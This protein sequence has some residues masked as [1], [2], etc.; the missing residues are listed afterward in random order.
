MPTDLQRARELFLHAVGK[1]P[2]EQWDDYVAAACGGDTGLRQQVEHFLQVHRE[3]G[4]FLER[5]AGGLKGTGLFTPAPADAATIP[6]EGPGAVL[7][8]YKLVQQIGEGGMG[9]VWMAQQTEPVKRLVALKVIKPGMDSRQVLVR[10]EA[11]RQ[12]LALMDHPHIAKVLDAGTTP[13][14]RPYFVMELVKG[15]PL[16]KYCDEHRLPLKERLEL[17]VPACQA[18]QHAHTK[19]VIHRDVKPSN[20]LVASYDGVPVPKV[21]DFGIAKATSQQLTEHALVTGFGTVVGT[22]E[23]MS[24]EQA[25]LNQLDIDTRSDIYSLGVLLYELLTGTTPLEKKRLK[26]AALLEVLRL[27]REEE[28]PKPSTRLSTTDELPVVAANRGL[29]PKKLSGLVRGELD[30]IVMK[31]L[32]KDRN[33]RYDTANGFAQDIQR[34]LADEPVQACPPSAGYR[35]KKFLRRNKGPVLAATLIVLALIGGVI[36]TT[37][38]MMRAEKASAAERLARNL[39][40]TA[41]EDARRAEEAAQKRLRQV[42]KADHILVSIFRDLNVPREE[43]NGIPLRAQLAE[44]LAKAAELLEGEA[45]GDAETVA[46]MQV[47]LGQT[48]TGL[49]YPEQAVTVLTKARHTLEKLLGANHAD[50]LTILNDLAEAYRLA[51]KLGAALQLHRETLDKRKATLGLDHHDTLA[52]MNCLAVAYGDAG[53][54]ELA[55]PLC[56]DCLAKTRAKRGAD[57]PDTLASM[58][59]LATLYHD[60]GQLE[61][62][63]PLHREVLEKTKAKRGPDHL[64]TFTSMNNLAETYRRAGQLE[65]ALPLALGTFSRCKAKLGPDNPYTLR[66]M[67]NLAA[68]YQDAGKLDLALPLHLEALERYKVKLGAD[69]PE[70]LTSMNNLADVYLALDKFDLALPLC[71]D[72]LEMARARLGADHPH[73]LTIMSNLAVAYRRA[74]KFDLA[75]PLAVETLQKRKAKLGADHPDTLKSMNTLAVVYGAVDRWNL[76]VPLYEEALEKMKAKRPDHRETI[77]CMNNLGDAYRATKQY[78]LAVPLLVETLQKRK[79]R[80]GADHRDTLIT[81]NNLALA[82][83]DGGHLD[84]ALPLFIETVAKL[85]AKLGAEDPQTLTAMNNLAL[86]YRSKGQFDVALPLYIETLQKR[87][88]RLGAD[89][90]DTLW[91]R[92]NL[93]GAYMEARKYAE[94]EPLLVGWLDKQRKPPADDLQV[95]W[96]LNR[97]GECRVALK[98]FVEAEEALRA[99]RDIFVKKAARSVMR[100]DTENQLGAALAGQKKF[101]EAEPLLT[102][103]AKFLLKSTPRLSADAKRR[104]AAAAGRVIEFYAAQGNAEEAARW[105]QLLEEAFPPP[106][107]KKEKP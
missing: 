87:Q 36:G 18:I 19:G 23:Y 12:A 45:V 40:D 54:F 39:A 85:K 72:S 90:P 89:H 24:P 74:G 104:G 13:E 52:S 32:D 28:P 50:T 92:H 1:L 78:D 31:A 95:A 48:L 44:R 34:Y 20:V 101:A 2:P 88:A 21:I 59:N 67:N 73:T 83:R 26:E 64:D 22:L 55:L 107:N 49:G 42:Q 25:Q 16:T 4:S 29:E 58:N 68:A 61:L 5:P 11:E 37:A 33:R 56:L 86:T 15:V 7:G 3:A 75:V 94:A 8:P 17:F 102:D 106:A 96:N 97:L 84:L 66:S 60:T 41:A 27:I 62:A 57:D 35:L 76:A 9:T 71:R 43:K 53:K 100:Y 93:A 80:L 81:M 82:Y 38:G 69:H 98:K 6:D 77:A 105:R 79:A 14:G 91:S 99:S 70:T 65:L 46:R 47:L 103:S 10:F 63:L 51:G 30:W